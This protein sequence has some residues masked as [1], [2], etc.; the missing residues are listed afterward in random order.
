MTKNDNNF[1][2]S[3]GAALGVVSAESHSARRGRSGNPLFGNKRAFSIVLL[4]PPPFARLGRVLGGCCV[5]VCL[6]SGS[7]SLDPVAR[8]RSAPCGCPSLRCGLNRLAAKIHGVLAF[9]PSPS[10]ARF[11][12]LA[13]GGTRPRKTAFS[14]QSLFVLFSFPRASS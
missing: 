6:V 2:R 12:A 8:P 9:P 10:L 1:N 4:L 3:V 7:P 13:R 11:A 14:E 5:F